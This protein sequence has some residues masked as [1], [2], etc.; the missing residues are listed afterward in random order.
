MTISNTPNAA[1]MFYFSQID[2]LSD[3]ESFKVQPIHDSHQAANIPGKPEFWSV[4]GKLKPS[5]AMNVTL[6]EFP[7][8]DFPSQMYAEL[9][10][11]M[12]TKLTSC[13]PDIALNSVVKETATTQVA[14]A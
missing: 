5:K 4:I 1:T 10:S 12:C 13:D 6:S 11:D 7:V 2:E 3:Y 8:A 9:F 14:N